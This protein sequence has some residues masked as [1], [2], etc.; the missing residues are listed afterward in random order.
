MGESTDGFGV[1]FDVEFLEAVEDGG[2]WTRVTRSLKAGAAK[3]YAVDRV[4]GDKMSSVIGEES[5]SVMAKVRVT[6]GVG[7]NNFEGEIQR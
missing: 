4:L 7:S 6:T 1:S 3:E 2:T 5:G